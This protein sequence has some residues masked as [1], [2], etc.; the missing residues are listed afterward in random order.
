MLAP[1]LAY[2]DA[3]AGQ[4]FMLGPGSFLSQLGHTSRRRETRQA[5][6]ALSV[7][8]IASSFASLLKNECPRAET[9]WVVERH[10]PPA[11]MKVAQGKQ[12]T[13]LRCAAVQWCV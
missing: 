11:E 1:A 12:L 4:G 7:A 10:E 5:G 6:V 13:L 8:G 9:F 2:R 3:P